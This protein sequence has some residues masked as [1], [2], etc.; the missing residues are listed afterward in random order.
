MGIKIEYFK[1]SEKEEI[2]FTTF[3]E[4]FDLTMKFGF[5]QKEKLFGYVSKLPEK[6]EVQINKEATLNCFAEIAD[7]LGTMYE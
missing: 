2:Q 1:I 3:G 7:A 6:Q 5:F 4:T